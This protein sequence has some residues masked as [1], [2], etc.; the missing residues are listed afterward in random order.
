M[1]DRREPNCGVTPMHDSIL[2]IV[3]P[4]LPTDKPEKKAEEFATIEFHAYKRLV[5]ES[6]CCV[7]DENERCL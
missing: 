3:K 2:C 5:I 6:D 1:S 4:G 7:T